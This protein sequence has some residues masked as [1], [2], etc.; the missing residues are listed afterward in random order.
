[1]YFRYGTMNASKSMQL[2]AVAHNYQE[3]DK[4]VLIFYPATDTRGDV[5]T[6]SSR[7]GISKPAI[8]IDN[9]MDIISAIIS[10]IPNCVLVDEAQ[11]LTKQNVL[12][13][14]KVVDE[15][16]IPVICYGLLRDFKN[17]LF[18]GSYNLVCYADKLEEI[19]T[20]C[21]YCNKKATMVLRFVNNEPKYEGE[22]VQIGGNES[23][24]SVCRKHYFD[25]KIEIFEKVKSAEYYYPAYISS[26]NTNKQPINQM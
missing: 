16:N 18:E 9:S 8:R 6:V 26:K 22:Q 20:I 7:I 1:M 10:D 5:D 17:E 21:T 13:F 24:K 25:P 19:K 14:V 15:L 11:F 3:Q 23:Y 2:L 12:D 4:K